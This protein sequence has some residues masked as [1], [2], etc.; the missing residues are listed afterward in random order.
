MESVDAGGQLKMI[1]YILYIYVNVLAILELRSLFCSV[2]PEYRSSNIILFFFLAPK[3]EI[4]GSDCASF[5][6]AS[7]K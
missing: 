2:T 5:F 7:P 6:G 4:Q 3:P 1:I